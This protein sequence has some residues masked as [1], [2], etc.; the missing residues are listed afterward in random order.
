ML[1][2][3]RQLLTVTFLIVSHFT[4]FAQ[5]SNPLL[6]GLDI[7]PYQN[8]KGQHELMVQYQFKNN[9]FLN[10][11]FRI[12]YAIRNVG[13]SGCLIGDG[14]YKKYAQGYFLKFGNDILLLKEWAISPM[15][16]FNSYK[17]SGV[18]YSTNPPEFIEIKSQKTFYGGINL[19]KIFIDKRN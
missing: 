4:T 8:I 17:S 3:N 1:P 12:G 15:I 6:I 7:S 9:R 2:M 14:V 16:I 10:P 11:Y 18:T 13:G 19:D 5:K